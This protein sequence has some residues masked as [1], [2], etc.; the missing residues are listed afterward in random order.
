MLTTPEIETKLP[1]KAVKT[2]MTAKK[3]VFVVERLSLK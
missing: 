1:A 2:P 3:A